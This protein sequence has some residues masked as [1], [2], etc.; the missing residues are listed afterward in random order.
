[1]VLQGGWRTWKSWKS[2]KIPGK[3]ICTWNTWKIPGK[4]IVPG[5]P[6]KYLENLR[7]FFNLDFYVI[8]F[9]T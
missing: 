6:G 9:L 3:K 2:W 7:F 8:I 5:I 4:K 1:M